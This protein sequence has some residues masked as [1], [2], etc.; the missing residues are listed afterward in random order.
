MSLHVNRFAS[1]RFLQVF[2]YDIPEDRHVSSKDLI[3][4]KIND[5]MVKPQ[6]TE[7]WLGYKIRVPAL[8]PTNLGYCNII[9]IKYYVIVS[10]VCQ[11]V[12]SLLYLFFSACCKLTVYHCDLIQQLLITTACCV[13]MCSICLCVGCFCKFTADCAS[14][15]LRG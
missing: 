2:A 3:K 7:Q 14:S 8:Q 4:R 5:G 6:K 10:I 11:T 1:W 12:N 9:S 15:V 13:T